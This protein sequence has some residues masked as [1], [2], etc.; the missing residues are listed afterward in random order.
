M[1]NDMKRVEADALE[2]I[3]D[4]LAYDGEPFTGISIE[5]YSSGNIKQEHSYLDGF[6][7]G[8][9]RDWYESGQLKS[10]WVALKGEAPNEITE[11]FE[12]GQMKSK[13]ISEHGVELRYEE[14][15]S[16]GNLIANREL[17]PDSPMATFLERMRSVKAK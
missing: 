7:N 12:N 17:S 13:K 14:W 8:L 16:L 9:C 10:E 2:F 4:A 15:D 1:N 6:P 3:D 11:W 5:K